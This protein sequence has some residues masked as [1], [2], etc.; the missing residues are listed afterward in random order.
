MILIS[1]NIGMK[2]VWSGRNTIEP[3]LCRSFVGFSLS[4]S[5]MPRVYPASSARVASQSV[6][7]IEFQGDT[8]AL[9]A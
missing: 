6:E 8:F 2:T 1:D 5:S 9:H 3:D 7:R 4:H